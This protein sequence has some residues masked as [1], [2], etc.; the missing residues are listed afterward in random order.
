MASSGEQ[1]Q[2]Q[3]QQQDRSTTLRTQA[4]AFCIALFSPPP[5]PVLLSTHFTSHPKIT[6]HGPT[7]AQTLLPFLGKTFTGHAACEQY[8]TLLGQ[9]L[10]MDL[11]PDAFPGPEAFIVDAEANMV[12]VVGKARFKSKA[13]GK[14]W[15]EEFIYRLS[16]FDGEGRV[17]HWEI[18]A[19]PLSAWVAVGGGGGG[20]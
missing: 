3:Q 1:Q 20:E 11:P 10:E 7:W 9:I 17:G 12:S 18:W 2:Q 5:P 14:A 16:E 15:D 8:F 19:D 13:T 6:E 4:H